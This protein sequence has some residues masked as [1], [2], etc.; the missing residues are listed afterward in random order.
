M[1]YSEK[2]LGMEKYSEL[3]KNQVIFIHIFLEM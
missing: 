3:L 1:C 2:D